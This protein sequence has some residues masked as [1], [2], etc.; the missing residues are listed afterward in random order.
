MIKSIPSS[1]KAAAIDR[2]GGPEELRVVELPVPKAD[3]NEVL[4]KV[5]TAGVGVWDPWLREGG[6]RGQPLPLV[7]GSDG[8][9]SVVAVG[10]SVRRFK[11]EDK[12]YG[13]AYNNPK[14]GFY[15]EYA[16][17]PE[18]SIALIP[19]EVHLDQAG[20]LAVSGLTG[21]LG[22]E[23]LKLKAG[24]SLMIVGASGGVGHVALQLSK[25]MGARVLAVASGKDGLSLVQSLGADLALERKDAKLIDKAMG[26]AP[27]GLDAI[28]APA[29]SEA[30]TGAFELIKKKGRIAYPNGVEPEPSA[31]NGVKAVGLDGYQTRRHTRGSTT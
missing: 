17:L 25:L 22:L 10:K 3:E 11:V 20:A 13:Y 15:A 30:L 28:L 5:D 31:A 14:G 26:F 18:D 6:A 19:K 8:A 23:T 1:M 24:Q 27:E 29:N 21:L 16:A 12:V 4:V 2:F 9:G 7:L